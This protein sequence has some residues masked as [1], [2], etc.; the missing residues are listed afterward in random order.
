MIDTDDLDRTLRAAFTVTA[1]RETTF[2]DPALRVSTRVRRRRRRRTAT[3]V[4]A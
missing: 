1:D 4:R 3:R 2:D